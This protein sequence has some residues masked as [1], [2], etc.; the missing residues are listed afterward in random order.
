MSGWTLTTG[1]YVDVRY[2]PIVNC[3]ESWSFDF[4]SV[5]VEIVVGFVKYILDKE[6]SKSILKQVVIEIVCFYEVLVSLFLYEKQ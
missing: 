1:D 4:S 3:W 6:K 2:H 5:E